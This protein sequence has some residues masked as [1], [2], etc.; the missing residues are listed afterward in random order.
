MISVIIPIYNS[1]QYLEESLA[2]AFGQTYSDV[3]YILV[4]DC[5]TDRSMDIARRMAEESPRRRNIRIISHENNRGASAARNTGVLEARGEYLFFLDSDD[6]ITPDCLQLLYQAAVDSDADF[7]IGNLRLSGARSIHIRNMPEDVSTLPPLQSF[8][9]RKWL[10][11]ACNK[12]ISRKFFIENK[13]FFPEDIQY[14]DIVWTF[15]LAEKTHS[16]AVIDEQTYIYRANTASFTSSS[17]S[18]KKLRSLIS[19]LSRLLN[20]YPSSPELQRFPRD[21]GRYLDFYRLNTA[22]LLLNFDGTRENTRNYY[23]QIQ[24]LKPAC[25]NSPYSLPLRLPFSL[26]SLLRPLYLLY[27]KKTRKN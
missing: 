15:K 20:A 19:Q 8:L 22:V 25:H 3:E 1:E 10:N 6:L 27:K 2:S 14:E 5:G 18:D 11:S 23:K 21:F 4:D 13:L 17:V 26:F 7:S 9:Q 24:A 16:I 12:L